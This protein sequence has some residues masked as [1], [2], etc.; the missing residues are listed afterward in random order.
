[1][2]SSKQFDY[3]EEKLNLHAT[4]V[5]SRAKKN[6]LNLNIHSENFYKRLLNIL[7]GWELVNA[8]AEKQNAEGIDL[9]DEANKIIISVSSTATKEKIKSGMVKDHSQYTGFTFKFL[10]IS[11]SVKNLRDKA[12]IDNPH[13]LKFDPETDILDIEVLLKS[14]IDSDRLSEL[15][16]VVQNEY[17][18]NVSSKLEI[19]KFDSIEYAKTILEED[20]RKSGHY[21]VLLAEQK[22]IDT[23]IEF[24]DDNE[25]KEII[26]VLDLPIQ[27]NTLNYLL[28]E[29]G[30]GKST[31]LTKIRTNQCLSITKGN[32]SQ[33]PIF[34]SIKRWS[35]KANFLNLFSEALKNNFPLTD[36]INDLNNGSFIILIDGLN[37]VD[38][39]LSKDCYQDVALFIHTYT[40]NKYVVSCRASDYRANIIPINALSPSFQEPKVYE[41]SRLS[42]K[43]II[44]YSNDYFNRFSLSA[45]GFLERIDIDGDDSW[46]STNSCIQLARIPLFLQILLESYRKTKNLPDSKA[47]LLQTLIGIIISRE[48]DLYRE[49]YN[50]SMIENVLSIFAFQIVQSGYGFRMPTTIVRNKLSEIVSSLKQTHSIPLEVKFDSFWD[51]VTSANFLKLHTRSETEWLHQL[52]RDYFLGIEIA[53]IWMTVTEE[54]KVI[55]NIVSSSRWDMAF[56]IALDLLND[57]YQGAELL[58]LLVRTDAEYHTQ[59]A[60]KS[61]EGLTSGARTNLASHFIK[62]ILDHENPE[63]TDLEILAIELPF[64]EIAEAIEGHFYH[65]SN[66]EMIGML[67]NALSSMVIEHL[68]KI[69]EQQHD[70]Y[71]RCAIFQKRQFNYSDYNKAIKRCQELLMKKLKNSHEIASFYAIKG[72]WEFDKSA[73]TEQLLVLSKSKDDHIKSLVM[74]L[75]DEWGIT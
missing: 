18:D 5:E 58:W 35:C 74:E 43:Q 73:C 10:S 49:N 39:Y 55:N 30:S 53:R 9:K 65:T 26:S 64:I 66:E 68:P 54:K 69:V 47:K 34:I 3:I 24:F 70:S 32:D 75:V 48:K 56:T 25:S 11:K 37:E 8:N 38:A 19:Q 57:T 60:V 72:L 21:T 20:S 41:I 13:N 12:Y 40:K 52:I 36:L 16:E 6:L 27:G 63:S 2:N 33:I 67:I 17:P 23:Y 44:A 15:Y 28:G 45:H 62:S 1:M 14:I 46:N 4:R 61:F 42:K 29:S 31:S 51:Q 7:Y 59:N 71:S 50:E 22:Q